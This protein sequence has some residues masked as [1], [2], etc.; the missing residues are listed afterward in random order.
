MQ[1]RIAPHVAYEIALDRESLD[2]EEVALDNE[3]D[4][5]LRYRVRLTGNVDE[6]WRRAF[7]FVQL[8]S[9]GFYRYRLDTDT[10]TVSFN[11]RQDDTIRDIG[12]VVARLKAFL[13]VVNR[14]AT[15][16]DFEG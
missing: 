8:N 5:G 2:R 10:P 1:D 16:G 4:E 13:G 6:H 3:G 12:E 7:H 14:T 11:A 15:S 9:T